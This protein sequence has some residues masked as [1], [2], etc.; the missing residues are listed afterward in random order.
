MSEPTRLT[1]EELAAAA[2]CG[3]LYEFVEAVKKYLAVLDERNASLVWLAGG[4]REQACDWCAAGRRE[5][6][7]ARRTVDAALK[8][9]DRPVRDV[10]TDEAA[11]WQAERQAA[12]ADAETP[13]C[14]KCRQPARLQDGQPVCATCGTVEG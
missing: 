7:A 8:A 13:R 12:Q 14:Q 6:L 3:P 2:W 5:C 1:R 4:S 11:R 9:F 10:L